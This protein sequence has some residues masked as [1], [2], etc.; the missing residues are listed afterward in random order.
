MRKQINIETIMSVSIGLSARQDFK[1]LNSKQKK[2]YCWPNA[3]LPVLSLDNNPTL[4]P[5]PMES[6]PDTT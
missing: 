5:D 2:D 3:K 1:Q 6:S 4:F